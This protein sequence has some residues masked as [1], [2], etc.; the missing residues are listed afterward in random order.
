MVEQGIEVKTWRPST[1]EEWG[2]CVTPAQAAGMAKKAAAIVWAV[3]DDEADPITVEVVG[4]ST[5]E[6]VLATDIRLTG[7]SYKRVANHQIEWNQIR[8]LEE[9]ATRL[10]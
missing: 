7:P 10:R 8:P 3:A 4:W 9:L 5:P 1:W 2:R 6:D